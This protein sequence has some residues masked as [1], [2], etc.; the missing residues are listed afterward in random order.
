[1]LKL[2]TSISVACLIPLNAIAL[3]SVI[4][5]PG[6][7][8]VL[9]N[10]NEHAWGAY[11]ANGILVRSG[12]ASTGADWCEDTERVCHTRTGT[13]RVRSL[14]SANCKSPSFPLPY[15]GAPMP[16]CMYFNETQALHGHASVD[17]VN[18]SH[19]CV[20]MS[21]SD[22]RWLR[23]HFVELGTVVEIEPYN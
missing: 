7:K 4:D 5:P 17:R 20:R 9:V 16:Y 8:L 14:G 12:I 22:A 2:L 1:M 19:G 15:G 6:V 11:N 21:N 23:Y 10:P 3:P 18:R 13:F